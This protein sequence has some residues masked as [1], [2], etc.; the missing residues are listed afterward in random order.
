MKRFTIKYAINGVREVRVS[1]FVG[2]PND[3]VL[4][5]YR[6]KPLIL[7]HLDTLEVRPW[8]RGDDR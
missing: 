3:A 7:R 1:P 5:L 4:W 8:Q 6:I 2:S